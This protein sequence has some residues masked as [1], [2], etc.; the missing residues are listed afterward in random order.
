MKTDIPLKGETCRVQLDKIGRTCA[1]GHTVKVE[2]PSPARLESE[3]PYYVNCGG[4][5]TRH[6]TY[7]EE[8]EFKRQKVED[9]LRRIGGC[10]TPVSVIYGADN[11]QRYRNKA[12]FPM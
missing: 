1:W 8:L 10:D 9:C 7:G 2:V 6:M 4:C 3:C 11:T 12:Q 5:A